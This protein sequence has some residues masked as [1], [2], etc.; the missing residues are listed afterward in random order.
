MDVFLLHARSKAAPTLAIRTEANSS[1]T[2]ISPP[3]ETHNAIDISDSNTKRI[4]RLIVKE[5]VEARVAPEK[6]TKKAADKA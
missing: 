5:A 4:E 1:P 3:Y 2:M 6:I